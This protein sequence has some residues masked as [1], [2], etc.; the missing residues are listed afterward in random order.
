VLPE[1][2]HKLTTTLPSCG[3][4]KSLLESESTDDGCFCTGLSGC[5]GIGDMHNN[6]TTSAIVGHL[7]TFPTVFCF[8]IPKQKMLAKFTLP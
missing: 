2:P 3:T 5:H 1:A 7:R 4:L 6:K 8:S